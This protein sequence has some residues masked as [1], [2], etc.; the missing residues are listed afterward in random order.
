MRGVRREAARPPVM[1][2]VVVID[3]KI[4]IK[5]PIAVHYVA[6]FIDA[7]LIDQGARVLAEL[8]VELEHHHV[9]IVLFHQLL[10]LRSDI[11]VL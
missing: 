3:R 7:R 6:L 8:L 1:Q 11:D 4:V 5:I 9:L 2:S 10:R